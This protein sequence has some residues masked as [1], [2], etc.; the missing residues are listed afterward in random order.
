MQQFSER[1]HEKTKK[2]QL[3]I[4]RREKSN[5]LDTLTSLDCRQLKIFLKHLGKVPHISL[6]YSK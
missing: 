1:N 3:L 6:V 4:Y 5:I 2:I